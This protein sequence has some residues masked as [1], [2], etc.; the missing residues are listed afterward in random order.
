MEEGK[1]KEEIVFTQPLKE[2]I[3]VTSNKVIKN[4]LN[5]FDI[6]V[7][8]D[9]MNSRVRQKLRSIIL[10]EINDLK[11]ECFKVLSIVL[12]E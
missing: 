5:A 4:I 9:S 8:A 3:E 10:D 12:R 7:D 1:F 2:R 11:R 6:T